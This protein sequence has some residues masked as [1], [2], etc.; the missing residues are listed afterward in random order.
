MEI[1]YK[2]S[3][4]IVV[5][6]AAGVPVQTKNIT[7]KD[8]ESEIKKMLS[9]EGK[10]DPYLAVINR[11]DQPV[12]G[13]VLF[14][15]NKQAATK[16]SDD[17]TKG[18]I[19]KYYKAEVLGEFEQKEGVLEDMI[20]KDGK[21]NMSFR[22]DEKDPRYKDAKK[23]VLEYKEVSPGSLEIK[24]ITGRHHQIRMQ[25]ANAGHPILGDTKYGNEA[26]KE[27]ASKRGIKE[28]KLKAY[29]LEINHPRTGERLE[30]QI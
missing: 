27:E 20:Y 17:L 28:L 16:L 5:N 21:T 3:D 29:K 2:D 12:S 1:I 24:L 25:L 4:I 15:L 26:S 11:L 8:L 10:K 6:K 23:A 30:Y 19:D 13:L 9:A 14:A 7:Q 22:V 18:R